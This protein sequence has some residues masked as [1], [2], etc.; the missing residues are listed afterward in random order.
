MLFSVP[1]KKSRQADKQDEDEQMDEEGEVLG[2]GELIKELKAHSKKVCLGKDKAKD[3]ILVGVIGQPNTGKSTLI[4]TLKKER[5]Q[6]VFKDGEKPNPKE[7][8]LHKNI[9]ISLTKGLIFPSPEEVDKLI[10]R[11]ALRIEEIK[12]PIAP[13]ANLVKLVNRQELLRHFRISDFKD[14]N[15]LLG[16]I[17]KKKGHLQ[18]GG[19]ANVEQAAR[20][21]IREF[22]ASKIKYQSSC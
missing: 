3:Y 16:H 20:A 17:A 6:G 15:E 18:Q 9:A 4:R 12:D 19:K 8:R 22:L 13:I 7:L 10:L 1:N 21:I 5:V 14:T 2:L 11:Q